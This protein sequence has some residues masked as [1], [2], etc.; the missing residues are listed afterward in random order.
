LIL[1]SLGR[2]GFLI[3]GES[4]REMEIVGRIVP[5]EEAGWIAV[6]NSVG[7]VGSSIIRP[8]PGELPS[9]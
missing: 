5:I 6:F 4:P 8:K 7:S 1:G 2:T 9:L 3:L